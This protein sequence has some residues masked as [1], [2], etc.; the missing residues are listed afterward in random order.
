[1]A[2]L[3][4]THSVCPICLKQ[5]PA[6]LE[7]DKDNVFLRKHCPDHGEFSCLV[8]EGTPDL[9][10]WTSN[11]FPLARPEDRP[12]E[13]C[14][15]GCGLCIDHLQKSCTVVVEVTEK[16]QLKCPVCF[17]S[18]GDGFEPDFY[19]LEKLLHDVHRKAP[20]AILQFSGGEPTLR[21][22]L[23]DLIRLASSLKFP[24]IQ[25]N[26]NG[27][28]LAQESGYGQKLK[29]AGLSWVFLQ[30]DGLRKA[31]YTTLRGKQ[32]LSDKVRAIDACKDAGLGVVLVP[33]IV[34]GVNDD[35]M[36]DI[37]RFGLSRFPAVRG[38][39]FQPISYFG[40]FPEPP[41]DEMRLTLPRIMREL[42]A[43]TDGMAS[44]SHFR[45]SRCEHERCS[46]R[47]VYLVES[48]DKIIPL[49]SEPC[50]CNGRSSDEGFQSSVESIRRRW[51]ADI[52]PKN[53]RKQE[54]TPQEVDAQAEN[55]FERFIRLYERGSFSISAMAFQ[56]G[57]NLDL[58]RLRFCC[59][60]VAAPD[61][62]FVPFCAWNLTARNGRALHRHR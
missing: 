49:T 22:D 28:R 25:L 60:H 41:C 44:L 1:M 10:T 42:V 17:A 12:P 59:I 13:T 45:P 37:V 29:E 4:N 33:T 61:G 2:I 54:E 50:C 24:G 27:L 30:F 58:E 16:C 3:R 47:A 21:D 11:R 8:W 32:L 48:P 62:R 46:F 7:S 23:T 52:S 56:D 39:H 19:V 36:G 34:K 38:V 51:G 18:A 20:G 15:E 53:C 43:Q 26:T 5:I 57:E 6:L 40:R 9:E 31:T 35:E 14:P 55:A